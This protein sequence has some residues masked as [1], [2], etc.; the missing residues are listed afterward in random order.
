MH[1]NVNTFWNRYV[2]YDS[3]DKINEYN[4]ITKF[5]NNGEMA[6]EFFSDEQFFL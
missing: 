6:G 1:P 4:D 5:N 3:G 2:V